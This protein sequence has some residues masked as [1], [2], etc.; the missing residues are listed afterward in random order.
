MYI[1]GRCLH[2]LEPAVAFGYSNAGVQGYKARLKNDFVSDLRAILEGPTPDRT[3][4][5]IHTA[6][7][8]FHHSVR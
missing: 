6:V 3:H 7:L 8:C 1:I 4:V 5:L 2:G